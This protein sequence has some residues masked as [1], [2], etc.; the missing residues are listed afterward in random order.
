MVYY[1]SFLAWM[2][3]NNLSSFY[4]ALVGII[5]TVFLLFLPFNPFSNYPRINSWILPCICMWMWT[6][7]HIVFERPGHGKDPHM[8]DVNILLS[9]FSFESQYS[10]DDAN[11][12]I[13]P[14]SLQFMVLNMPLE[15][16][17]TQRV[18]SLRLNLDSA[19]ASSLGSQYLWGR[20][21][22]IL[23]R[24]ESSWSASQQTIMA[25]PITWLLRTAIISVMIFVTSWQGTQ[26]QNGWIDLQE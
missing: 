3:Q 1:F 5:N 6:Y 21:A 15:L 8:L 2:Q 9:A 26:C 14:I 12:L 22:W 16:M 18:V 13:V 4:K 23:S 7:R 17:T 20:Q 19:L 10:L 24:L 11:V 25:I